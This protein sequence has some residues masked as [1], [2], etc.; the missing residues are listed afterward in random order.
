MFHVTVT[1]SFVVAPTY[2]PGVLPNWLLCYCYFNTSVNDDILT[3]S[4]HYIVGSS[5]CIFQHDRSDQPPPSASEQSRPSRP[6]GLFF[7]NG[8]VLMCR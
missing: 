4:F 6:L 8:V 5:R 1:D 3:C 2:E 7:Q